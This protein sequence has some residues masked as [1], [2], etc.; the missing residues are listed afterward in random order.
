MRKYYYTMFGNRQEVTEEQYAL[1]YKASP[2]YFA[3]L[4]QK[5]KD[6]AD[7]IIDVSPVDPEVLTDWKN[8]LLSGTIEEVKELE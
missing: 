3:R 5:E 2:T 7:G 6:V 4:E 8:G 1:A